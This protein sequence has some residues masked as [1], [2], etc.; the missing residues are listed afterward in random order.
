MPMAAATT[1]NFNRRLSLIFLSGESMFDSILRYTQSTVKGGVCVGR[2][3]RHLRQADTAA[4][5]R[6]VGGRAIPIAIKKALGS[7]LHRLRINRQQRL[8][9]VADGV[10]TDPANI[11][12]IEKGMQT[13]ALD[14]LCAICEHFGVAVSEV[15]KVAEGKPAEPTAFLSPEAI[16]FAK[17]WDTLPD[18]GKMKVENSLLEATSLMRAMPTYFKGATPRR[19]SFEEKL[20]A[21]ADG[22]ETNPQTKRRVL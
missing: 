22:S 11:W 10:A 16:A 3:A 17:V 4:M 20:K 19:K 2:F 9:D 12:R 15:F 6:K 21:L 14:M 18:G 13:A 1:V 8:E 5:P 7:E